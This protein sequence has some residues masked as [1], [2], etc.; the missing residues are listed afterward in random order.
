MKFDIFI[1]ISVLKIRLM[2]DLEYINF[3]GTI[4]VGFEYTILLGGLNGR[5]HDCVTSRGDVGLCLCQSLIGVLFVVCETVTHL[6]RC[7]GTRLVPRELIIQLYVVSRLGSPCGWGG[8]APQP[9]FETLLCFSSQP[10]GAPDCVTSVSVSDPAMDLPP[11]CVRGWSNTPSAFLC[12][13][14]L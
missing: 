5:H 12:D 6:R 1:L 10:D 3:W 9:H 2:E 8:K 13:H 4:L 14:G 7:G 11:T